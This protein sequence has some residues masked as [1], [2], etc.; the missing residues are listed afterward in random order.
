MDIKYSP[1][2]IKND[3]QRMVVKKKI[4]VIKGK[5]YIKKYH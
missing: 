4:I 1:V 3:Q 2:K 5:R